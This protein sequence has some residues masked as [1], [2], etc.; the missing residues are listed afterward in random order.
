M[1][2]IFSVAYTKHPIIDAEL[3]EEFR[4]INNIFIN[5]SKPS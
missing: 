2:Y 1:G 4:T 3:L 5:L